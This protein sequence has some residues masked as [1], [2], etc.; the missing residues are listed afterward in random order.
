MALFNV[1]S[2]LLFI[3]RLKTK[4]RSTKTRHFQIKRNRDRQFL[5]KMGNGS[6]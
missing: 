4:A 3:A 6:C 2:L 5:N 1:T